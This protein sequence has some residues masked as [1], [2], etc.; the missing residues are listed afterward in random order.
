MSQDTGMADKNQTHEPK[1]DTRTKTRHTNQ[2]QTHEPKHDQ[3]FQEFS[4]TLVD[5]FDKLY[6]FGV[7]F[8]NEFSSHTAFVSIIYIF[9]IIKNIS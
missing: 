3:F 1:P 8:S 4:P 6:L 7:D 9:V 2:N 5:F